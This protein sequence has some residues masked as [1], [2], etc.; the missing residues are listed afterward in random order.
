MNLMGLPVYADLSVPAGLLSAEPNPAP[1][2][3]LVRQPRKALFDRNSSR[4][5][6]GLLD[7]HVFP[8]F[9]LGSCGWL[10]VETMLDIRV[11]IVKTSVSKFLRIWAMVGNSVHEDVECAHLSHRQTVKG[12][13]GIFLAQTDFDLAQRAGCV[14]LD[15]DGRGWRR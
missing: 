15:D 1:A 5:F 13:K 11:L 12:L 8:L 6:G 10:R 3:A 14:D 2:L 4:A 7:Q 9:G